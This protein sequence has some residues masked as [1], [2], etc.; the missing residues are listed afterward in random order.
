MLEQYQQKFNI[1]D[2]ILAKIEG[3]PPWPAKIASF[4]K[5]ATREIYKVFFFADNCFAYV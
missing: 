3:Y 2:I 1:E 5:Q 4:I